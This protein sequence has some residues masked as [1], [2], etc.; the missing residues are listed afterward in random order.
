MRLVW[1][2]EATRSRNTIFDHIEADDPVAALRMD[3]LFS[4]CA[5]RL[6]VQPLMGRPG[7]VP[8]TRELIVHPRYVL[9]YDL[10]GDT[11]RIL[12]LLHTARRWPPCE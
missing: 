4:E 1:T 7:R 3:A 2:K 9:V 5:E 6:L 10:R 8:G 11:L 12:R